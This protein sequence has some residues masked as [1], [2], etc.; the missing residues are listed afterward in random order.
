MLM[1]GHN[2]L[3]RMSDRYLHYLRGKKVKDMKNALLYNGIFGYHGNI[4][5]VILIND[6]F[7]MCIVYV[8]A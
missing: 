3:V 8:C 7:A 5:Y 6:F 4:C 2:C 1:C